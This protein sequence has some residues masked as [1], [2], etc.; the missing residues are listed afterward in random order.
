MYT[1]HGTHLAL[2]LHPQMNPAGESR[3][4]QAGGTDRQPAPIHIQCRGRI[5]FSLALAASADSDSW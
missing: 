2:L 1:A 5:L 3:F 4:P